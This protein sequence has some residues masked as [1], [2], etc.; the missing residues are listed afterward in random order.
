MGA[1]TIQLTTKRRSLQEKE[2]SM[3]GL[4][5]GAR[6]VTN[7]GCSLETPGQGQPLKSLSWPQLQIF[8]INLEWDLI[9]INT[10]RC[11]AHKVYGWRIKRVGLKSNK[12]EWWLRR[13]EEPGNQHA[14]LRSIQIWFGNVSWRTWVCRLWKTSCQFEMSSLDL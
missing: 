7:I 8:S 14:A 13:Q 9:N 5:A 6:A 4:R 10:L 1:D 2:R 12:E 3:Y 11:P